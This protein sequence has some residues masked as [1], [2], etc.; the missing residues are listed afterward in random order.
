[1]TKN[2]T[3]SSNDA[4]LDLTAPLVKADV[5]DFSDSGLPQSLLV[6]AA[7]R[8][9]E[10]INT[11]GTGAQDAQ[12]SQYTVEMTGC[13]QYGQSS[14]SDGKFSVTF[15]VKRE[16]V[17]GAGVTRLRKPAAAVFFRQVDTTLPDIITKVDLTNTDSTTFEVV[18]TK[19]VG[20]VMVYIIDASTVSAWPNAS[21]KSARGTVAQGIFRQKGSFAF[22][23]KQCRDKLAA[24]TA[25]EADPPDWA[26]VNESAIHDATGVS[27]SPDKKETA[28]NAVKDAVALYGET[29]SLDQMKAAVEAA[30]K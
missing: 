6:Q 7:Y 12:L 1:M 30:V 22:L 19:A 14:E 4:P 13:M 18:P 9:T 10:T 20:E 21:E 28:K 25:G 26:N 15:Q 24:E 2:G 3:F 27:I 29:I 16:N 5:A 8:A 17:G 23:V 11:P